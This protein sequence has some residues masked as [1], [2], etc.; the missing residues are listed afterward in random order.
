MDGSSNTGH[1]TALRRLRQVMAGTGS[2][3]DRLN[4]IVKIV[5][6]EMAAEVCSIY[7]Q[8]AGDILELFAT[9]GLNP[10]SVHVTRLQL[11]EGLVGTVA[12]TAEPLNLPDAQ[13]HPNFSYRPET[14]E[15]VFASLLGVPV[16]RGGRVRGVLVIQ[17]GDK[18]TYADEE[19]EALQIIAV[20][21]AEI[22]ASGN[23]VTADEKAQLGGGR[24]FRSSRHA[25]LAINSGLAVGQAVLHT[26][27]VSI[28]QM[29]AD[30]T[31]TE[32]ERLRES[33][34]TCM[35]LSTSFWHRR[36]CVP[37]ANIVMCSIPIVGLPRIVA[38]CAVSGK[39]SIAG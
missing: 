17:N 19:E 26:P 36:V 18:R 10:D 13:A 12:L 9:Q 5:A 37:M 14:G 31:E 1:R 6:A 29:F 3:Q 32:H 27:N 15:E 4:E 20:V 21:I 23:L 39:V 16:I 25:G 7:V 33:M 30:D 38:G 28:R 8:R 11:G 22:I 34:A 24:S 2:A 35:P